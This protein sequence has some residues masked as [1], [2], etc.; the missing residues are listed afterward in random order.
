MA[1]FINAF[2]NPIPWE[3]QDKLTTKQQLVY[4]YKDLLK[5]SKSMGKNLAFF[6]CLYGTIECF[7]ERHRAKQDMAN[8]IITGCASGGLLGAMAGPQ[9]ACLG[10]ASFTAFS[11]VIEFMFTGIA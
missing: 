7:V 11:Y 9:A 3:L 1:L 8:H 4:S 6:G 10:C 5:K 2:Q